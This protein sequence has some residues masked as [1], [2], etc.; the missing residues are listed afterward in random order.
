MVLKYSCGWANF[1][2]VESFINSMDPATRVYQFAYDTAPDY[3]YTECHI[4]KGWHR[5]GG[6]HF[7]CRLMC[8]DWHYRSGYAPVWGWKK[9][10]SIHVYE[11]GRETRR[12]RKIRYPK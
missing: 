12:G 8:Q 1:A 7:T 4:I 11:D 6:D 3:R 9:F 10:G 2:E 5:Q